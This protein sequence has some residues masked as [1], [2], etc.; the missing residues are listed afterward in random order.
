M[1]SSGPV[2]VAVKDDMLARGAFS[3]VSR[4]AL[5]IDAVSPFLSAS[6]TLNFLTDCSRLP[7]LVSGIGA[8]FAGWE[9]DGVLLRDADVVDSLELWL[10]VLGWCCMGDKVECFAAACGEARLPEFEAR[11]S[12]EPDS[13]SRVSLR[14]SSDNAAADLDRL[15][16]EVLY[17][18][19]TGKLDDKILELNRM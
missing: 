19:D 11:P 8:V 16:W 1:S 15:W 13:S 12:S 10:R 18:G 2:L 9:F 5:E 6:T 4:I 7:D 14:R 3:E 17:S